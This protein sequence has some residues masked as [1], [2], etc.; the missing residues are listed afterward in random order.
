VYTLIEL[1]LNNLDIPEKRKPVI[2]AM[3]ENL[4]ED[5]V[6]SIVVYGSVTRGESTSESDVDTV[7]ILKDE[8]GGRAASIEENLDKIESEVKDVG[9]NENRVE[10]IGGIFKSCF[11]TTKE[12]YQK[13]DT[14]EIFGFPSFTKFLMPWRTLLHRLS[15][16]SVTVYGEQVKFNETE[17]FNPSDY[18]ARELSKGLFN[19]LGLSLL[20]LFYLPFSDRAAK[21]SMESYK[22]SLYNCS[23]ITDQQIVTLEGSIA[24]I[25]NFL[26]VQSLFKRFRRGEDISILSFTLEAPIAI[27]L[28]YVWTFKQSLLR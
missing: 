12:N 18:W 15:R 24:A 4:R 26:Q 28:N 7:V 1:D 25:P 11:V 19:Q 23:Y 20:A 10:N 5:E 16:D 9:E 6:E 17:D 13:A 3:E 27:L 2:R 21:Y 14:S 22:I 8:Y